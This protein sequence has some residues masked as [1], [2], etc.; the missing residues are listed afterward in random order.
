M[1]Q[2]DCCVARKGRYLSTLAVAA[3]NTD[4]KWRGSWIRRLRRAPFKDVIQTKSDTNL[5]VLPIRKAY[6]APSRS[7]YAAVV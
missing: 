6:V 5:S 7:I 2:A 1:A 4:W 3:L